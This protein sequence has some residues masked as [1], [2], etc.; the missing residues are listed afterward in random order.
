MLY[1]TQSIETRFFVMSKKP[2]PAEAERAKLLK[3]ISDLKK[4]AL[5]SDLIMAAGLLLHLDF[6]WL[7][8]LLILAASCSSLLNHYLR[9]KKL[10]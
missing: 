4:G 7:P 9:L 8:A 5:I 10:P 3:T 1:P 2:T 6:V